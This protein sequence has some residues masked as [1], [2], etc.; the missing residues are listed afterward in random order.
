LL[1]FGC[2]AMDKGECRNADGYA[3][4]LNR[5]LELRVQEAERR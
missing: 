3:V 1:A 4:G 2:A 5:R